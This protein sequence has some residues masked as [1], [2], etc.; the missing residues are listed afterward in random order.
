MI[1]GSI[2]L[3]ALT[4]F[5][6]AA[7]WLYQR[8]L[9]F[10]APPPRTIVV[11]GY[12]PAV[13]KTADGL[14]L[15]A[16]YRPAAPGKSTLIFFHGNADTLQGSAKAVAG[17]VAAGHGALLPEY[18]GYGAN[19]GSPAE[20]GFYADGAAALAF[21]RGQGVPDGD[22]VIIGNSIGSGVA[23][24]LAT[25]GDFGGLALVSPYTRLSAVIS[26]VAAGLPVDFLVRDKF[27]NLSRL[28]HITAPIL[29]LHGR[30]DRVIAFAQGEALGAVPGV[31]F[32]AFD[33][34]HELAYL[35]EAQSALTEWLANRRQPTLSAATA[36][37]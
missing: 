36:A 7:L 18:R 20:A 2:I 9:I 23:T 28:P 32:R 10:P 8:R 14:S 17:P 29:V 4:C 11:A 1:R 19:P 21:V 27:D 33:A 6:L 25:H 37:P 35:P 15:V 31:R 22:I 16:L 30:R 3:V 24:E 5:A 34:G 13:L 12:D 26:A